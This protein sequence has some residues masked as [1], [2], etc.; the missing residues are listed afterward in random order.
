[1]TPGRPECA[2]QLPHLLEVTIIIRRR[3]LRIIRRR[4]LR[5]DPA[6]QLQ[7]RKTHCVRTLEKRPHT[8]PERRQ[9][10]D[11][12]LALPNS[13]FRLAVEL[14]YHQEPVHLPV[15]YITHSIQN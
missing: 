2:Q 11:L 4:H 8:L 9:S 13:P 5:P 7:P 15:H 6:R 1:M 14:T 12:P 10:P 3:H